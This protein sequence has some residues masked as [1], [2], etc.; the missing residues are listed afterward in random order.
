MGGTMK[1][2][3]VLAWASFFSVVGVLSVN[4]GTSAFLNATGWELLWSPVGFVVG[5]VCFYGTLNWLIQY[6]KE[7][8]SS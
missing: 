7:D 2:S 4:F 8:A 3:L 1:R 5:G 6:L